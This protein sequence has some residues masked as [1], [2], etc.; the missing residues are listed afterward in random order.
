MTHELTNEWE[1]MAANADHEIS[2][3]MRGLKDTTQTH[4]MEF[5]CTQLLN[6]QHYGHETNVLCTIQNIFGSIVVKWIELME[7][8]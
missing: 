7:M 3:E 5:H 4:K 2:E 8:K 6:L 1:A